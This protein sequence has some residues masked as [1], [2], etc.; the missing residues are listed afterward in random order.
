[1]RYPV[2]LLVPVFLAG[3]A[4]GPDPVVPQMAIPKTWHEEP[5]S[6]GQE[7]FWWDQYHDPILSQLIEIALKNNLDIQIASER[8]REARAGY[9]AQVTALLP[10]FGVSGHAERDQ[11][12]V[13]LIGS[14]FPKPYESFRAGFDMA[15]EIDLFGGT[16][17]QLDAAGA[18][19]RGA[20]WAVLAVQQS[21][22]A[23][24]V[25]SYVEYQQF[26][27]LIEVTEQNQRAQ[28]ETAQLV[29]RQLDAGGASKFDALRAQSQAQ[30]VAS[31]VP[32]YRV[33]MAQAQ[34]KMG[35]LLGES[36]GSELVLLGQVTRIPVVQ[37]DPILSTPL[38]VIRRRPDIVIA[39]ENL[40]AATYM[41]GVAM[42]ELY[43]KISV[44]GF[45]GQMSPA[46]VGLMDSKNH[47]FSILG[48]I[49]LPLFNFGRLQRQVDAAD[50][51]QQQALLAYKKTVLT[52]LAEVETVLRAYHNECQRLATLMLAESSAR[53]ALVIAKNQQQQGLT[54]LF[55]LLDVERTYYGL[56]GQ[57]IQSQALVALNLAALSKA[58]GLGC[59]LSQNKEKDKHD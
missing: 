19:S 36:D 43:P 27:K 57:L 3:C 7:Q 40:A 26:R 8:L 18:Q 25:K 44:Q 37:Q 2:L 13:P 9:D 34:Y 30:A 33:G 41:T 58:L 17:R 31:Q 51:R 6:R 56:Q 1:M 15:W 20:A 28:E 11:N 59:E 14:I 4:L 52:V 46:S 22:V 16:R 53:Q 42:A 54:S 24:V 45:L 47:S 48:G 50:A 5:N 23:E 29:D 38:E 35:V 55:E 12:N 39:E 32:T 10:S 49:Q 21:I